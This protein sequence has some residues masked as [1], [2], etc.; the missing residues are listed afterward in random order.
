MIQRL[1][2]I[3]GDRDALTLTDGGDHSLQG[4]HRRIPLGRHIERTDPQDRIADRQHQQIT[5]LD[6]RAVAV[7]QRELARDRLVLCNRRGHENG[8]GRV[9]RGDLIG[10]QTR[11]A[12]GSR[13]ADHE[14][15][16]FATVVVFIERHEA[17]QGHEA[18]LV[19][20]RQF[21]QGV[22][23]IDPFLAGDEQAILAHR[24]LGAGGD[25]DLT[26]RVLGDVPPLGA[27]DETFGI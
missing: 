1:G 21:H 8:P 25:A 17:A 26:A 22:V 3:A 23:R 5:E 20:A 27:D 14:G 4:G 6:G 12:V 10:N 11:R 15:L 18:R 7:E 24:R 2:E 9:G 19:L 16:E 13:L